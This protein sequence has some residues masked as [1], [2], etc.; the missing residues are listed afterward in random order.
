MGGAVTAALARNW[1]VAAA[2]FSCFALF[3]MTALAQGSIGPRGEVLDAEPY[4]VQPGDTLV[5]SVL[6]DPALDAEV[7]V[8]PDGRIS[9]PMAGT[10]NAAG[11][12]PQRIEAIVR[13]R[14]RANFV[15]SP[16]VTVRVTSLSPEDDLLEVFVVGEVAR[17]GRYEYEPESP[18]TVIKALSL[19][20]GPGP[21][22]ARHRI[23]V[24]ELV[25]EIETLRIFD[26]DAFEDGEIATSHDL[27]LLPDGAVIVVPERALFE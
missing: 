16:N 13:D 23:Q 11:M 10:I 4:T 8:L 2:A 15:E 22:A 24:R 14:L 21:F 26:Y 18:I 6:E 25:G 17:P 12:T 5:V 27:G 20:G 19:A 1:M 7:L 3:A 9:L